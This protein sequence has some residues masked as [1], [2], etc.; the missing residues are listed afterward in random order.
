MLNL[1]ESFHLQ[2]Q[3]TL[4]TKEATA[5]RILL[6]GEHPELNGFE[7]GFGSNCIP[8]RAAGSADALR[9]LRQLAY[10]VVI[11]DPSTSIE[12]DLALLAEIRQIRPGVKTIV[13]A[14][15]SAPEEIIS[16]LRAHV[17]VCLTPPFNAE[18]IVDYASRAPA[19]SD[20]DI[21]VLSA[22]RD[23]ISLR[24]NCSLLTA[25]RVVLF[26][27][28]LRSELAEE[29]REQL[30][31]A[32][33]EI[34]MNAIEHGA[35]FDPEKVVEVAAVHTARTIVFYVR[36]PGPGFCLETICNAA[37]SNPSSSPTAHMARRAEQ[38]LRPGGFGIL[39]ARGVVD[40]LIYSEVGN[41][42]LLI[43]YVI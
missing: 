1:P 4:R 26:L 16:A 42:V 11:T 35:A 29:P 30:M 38:G 10:D 8:E 14:P 13:M 2:P 43:K 6:I 18:E 15:S 24:V 40:E 27:K 22:Q 21:E 3:T 39:L 41:E 23:W 36:D 9:R 33:R 12:E 34:L 32:F 5:N 31:M 7:E 19:E 37:I 20:A 25:E 28:Q 17:F